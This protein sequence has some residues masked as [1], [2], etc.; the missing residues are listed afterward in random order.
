[1]PVAQAQMD[2]A[3]GAQIGGPPPPLRG[4]PRARPPPSGGSARAG[5]PP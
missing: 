5:S 3:V 4:S 1:V 2:V